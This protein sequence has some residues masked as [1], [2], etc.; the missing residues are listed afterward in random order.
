MVLTHDRKKNV[1]WSQDDFLPRR[2]V[3]DAHVALVRP[4]VWDPDLWEPAEH[5]DYLWVL[6]TVPAAFAVRFENKTIPLANL[7][8]RR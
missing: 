1:P 2:A 7:H 5:K 6:H 3:V 8:M 4:V